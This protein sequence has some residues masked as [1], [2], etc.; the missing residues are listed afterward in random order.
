MALV[1]WRPFGGLSEAHE[2]VTRVFDHFFSRT[3]YRWPQD[4]NGGWHP[5][6]D[7]SENKEGFVAIATQESLA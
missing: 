7:I 1:R 4:R 6:V 3:P 2:D 5:S